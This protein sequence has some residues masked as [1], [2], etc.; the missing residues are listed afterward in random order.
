MLTRGCAGTRVVV[1][2]GPW[3]LLLV[4]IDSEALNFG[5]CWFQKPLQLARMLAAQLA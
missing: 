3:M 1:P 5:S 2:A 4:G